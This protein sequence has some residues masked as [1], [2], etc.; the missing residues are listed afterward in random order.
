MNRGEIKT[1]LFQSVN[2]RFDFVS[3]V[4]LNIGP[5]A[6]QFE[7]LF[8]DP[9]AFRLEV[10]TSCDRR[11]SAVAKKQKAKFTVF[12]T[13]PETGESANDVQTHV[14]SNK[15]PS[16]S[17]R[18]EDAPPTVSAD[19]A[20]AS[21]PTQKTTNGDELIDLWKVP[22]ERTES[23]EKPKPVRTHI[24]K[25]GEKKKPE[26]VRGEETAQT[27]SAKVSESPRQAVEGVVDLWKESDEDTGSTKAVEN[28]P[29]GDAANA[30]AGLT[31][32]E[33]FGIS[34]GVDIFKTMNSKDLKR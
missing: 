2:I 19:D 33:L 17:V 14:E 6:C 5:Q 3:G 9:R 10:R 27:D 7:T 32:E 34:L 15:N 8:I 30:K 1:C 23:T 11:G 26:P 25:G 4:D 20:K 12:G 21:R 22:E 18:S 24:A 16:E 28:E 29:T 31:P 13:I